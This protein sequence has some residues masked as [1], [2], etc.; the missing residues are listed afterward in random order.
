MVSSDQ[1]TQLIKMIHDCATILNKLLYSS[2]TTVHLLCYQSLQIG[3]ISSVEPIIS[4]GL[5]VDTEYLYKVSVVYH[6]SYYHCCSSSAP[7]ESF[8]TICCEA[9]VAVLD[10]VD[11]FRVPRNIRPLV[12]KALI[13]TLSMLILLVAPP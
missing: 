2:T 11:R 10:L 4:N 6:G 5:Q 7:F 12:I 9:K 13:M 8:C 1:L 3:K